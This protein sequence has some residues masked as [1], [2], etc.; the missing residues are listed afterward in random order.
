LGTSQPDRTG[1]CAPA[2]TKA[3]LAPDAQ[4]AQPTAGLCAGQMLTMILFVQRLVAMKG[5][6]FTELLAF[7]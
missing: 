2:D 5:K 1:G 6:L 4:V 7:Y 3:G